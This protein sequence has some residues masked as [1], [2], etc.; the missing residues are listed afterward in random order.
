MKTMCLVFSVLGLT[1]VAAAT[2][3]EILEFPIGSA[4]TG[5]TGLGLGPDGEIWFTESANLYPN[6]SFIP[7]AGP[8]AQMTADGAITEH[9]CSSWEGVAF[10][11]IVGPA[12]IP[13]GNVWTAQSGP[14]AQGQINLIAPCLPAVPGNAAVLPAAATGLIAGPDGDLWFALPLTLPPSIGRST[15]TG[16]LTTFPLPPFSTPTDLAAGPDGNVWF[17]D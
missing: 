13:G 16:L 17:T 9:H 15:A 4:W 8:L 14:G 7:V 10:S 2:A 1:A 11:S 6:H 3:Q 12:T 5:V